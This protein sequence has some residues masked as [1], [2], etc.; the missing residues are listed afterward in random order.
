MTLDPK[1]RE[2]LKPQDA[3]FLEMIEEHGW[4][5]TRVAPRVGEEGECFAYSAGLFFRF[6]QPEIVMFGLSLETMHLVI[7]SIGRQMKEG[8]KFVPEQSFDDLLDK[9]PCQFKYVDKSHYREHLG[10]TSWFYESHDYPVLQCFWPDR[11]GRFPWDEEC[12]AGTRAL[13]PF[14]FLPASLKTDQLQ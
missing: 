1:K 2:G 7:N 11:D 5:V 13:Q 4:A 3:K 14:L 10:W 9:Y 12:R 6:G 8:V